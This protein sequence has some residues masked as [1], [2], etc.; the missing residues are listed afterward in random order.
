MGLQ[1]DMKEMKEKLDRLVETKNGVKE[2][3]FRY[4]FG[5]KVGKSQRKK[6]Y[7]T[8]ITI[9]DNGVIGYNK[10]QIQEQTIMHDLIPRLATAEYI[11]HDKKGN[12][13]IIL[14]NY[15]VEPLP[16]NNVENFKK[17]LEN[18]S[19]INAYKILMARMES[20]KVTAKKKMA[21][22]LPWV[23]GIILA[24]IVIYAIMSGGKK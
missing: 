19:N 3:K 12:P 20:E 16:F 18:G 11:L 17:S 6:N 24:G 4:P 1:D 5:K 2:K 10:Y 21:S 22:W 15:S 13:V 23:I 9:N 7:V 8:V 14:P